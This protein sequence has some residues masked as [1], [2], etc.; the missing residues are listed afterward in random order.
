MIGRLRGALVAIRDGGVVVD[1]G[2]V[3]YDVA[4]TP[5]AVAGLPALGEEVVVHTHL[6]VRE[7]DMSLYGF[8]AATDRDLFRTLIS[9]SGVGPKVGLALMATLRPDQLR[10]AI[11]TE[12]AAALAMAPGVGK[13]S[14]QKLILEL[15]PKL[16]DAEAQVVQGSGV[17][18][19]R[20]ALENLGYTPE[21]IAEV[22]LDLDDEA[23]V[24]DQ[25]KAA[26]KL[27]GQARHA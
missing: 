7:D 21:E 3:G 23:P 2:G 12:D 10:R 20:Q 11:V 13:R 18:Q 26:L 27:L 19:V 4:M 16:A 24:A 25:L 8:T 14:A 17:A 15:R 6:Q 1:V 9:A 5:E 22:A